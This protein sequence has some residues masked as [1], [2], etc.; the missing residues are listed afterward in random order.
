MASHLFAQ[1]GDSPFETAKSNFLQKLQVDLAGNHKKVISAYQYDVDDFSPSFYKANYPLEWRQIIDTGQSS[2]KLDYRYTYRSMP[3]GTVSISVLPLVFPMMLNGN[4]KYNLFLERRLIPGFLFGVNG[5]YVPSFMREVF[6]SLLDEDPG[7]GELRLWGSSVFSILYKSV[8]PHIKLFGG[9]RFA[10]GAFKIDISNEF[11]EKKGINPILFA[12][13]ETSTDLR[14]QWQ[15]HEI[16]WGIDLLTFRNHEAIFCLDM[17]PF[18]A[19]LFCKAEYR[20]NRWTYGLGIHPD[21]VLILRPYV[22]LN[23][24]F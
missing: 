21:N 15:L 20:W 9:Y 10:Y 24:K 7:E 2:D 1:S 4:F 5:W 17:R 13:L 6:F 22:R 11:L 3:R 16:L 19:S 23:F 8:T 12:F 18:Q 14:I